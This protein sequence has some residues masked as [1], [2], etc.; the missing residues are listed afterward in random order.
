MRRNYATYEDRRLVAQAPNQHL[1]DIP[2]PVMQR[3][4]DVIHSQIFWFRMPVP[5]TSTAAELISAFTEP[6]GF[7]SIV[8]GG[9]TDSTSSRVQIVESRTERQWSS[10]YVPVRSI[11]GN[12]NEVAPLFY[13]GTPVLLEARD[14]VRGDFINSNSEP[15]KTACLYAEIIGN[16]KH[17][18]DGKITVKRSQSFWLNFDLAATTATTQPVNDDVL[19]WG[20]ITN[21]PVTTIGKI[22]N[23][24]TNFAW[25]SQNIPLRAM[26]GVDG[27][28]QQII[29]YH[30]PYLVPANVKMRCEINTAIAGQYFTFIC[31][32]ILM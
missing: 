2:A 22:S 25:S 6:E 4:R 16:E 29:R 18:G 1:N 9:W 15:A 5:F 13:W 30:R 32:R 24:S 20:A 14:Q 8:R 7:D 12:S 21:A 26:A 31:E 19:I 3:Q 23:E 10:V 27:Q 17:V 11:F 28:V